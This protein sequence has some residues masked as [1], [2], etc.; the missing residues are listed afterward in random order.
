MLSTVGYRLQE[1]RPSPIATWSN[2]WLMFHPSF[3][4]TRGHLPGKHH[5][6]HDQG[7]IVCGLCFKGRGVNSSENI[8]L[9]NG[10]FGDGLRVKGSTSS[11]ETMLAITSSLSLMALTCSTRET[12]PTR[13]ACSLDTSDLSLPTSRA[14]FALRT[15][16]IVGT[17]GIRSDIWLGKSRC[18]FSSSHPLHLQ[19][20]QSPKH[21]S[22]RVTSSAPAHTLFTYKY[23]NP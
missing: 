6:T 8:V 16:V 9:D 1:L 21:W 14:A 18:F 3:K 13:R 15:T 22:K 20:P 19:V 12:L 17:S 10:R 11:A 23:L 7:R 2:S 5:G 4:A